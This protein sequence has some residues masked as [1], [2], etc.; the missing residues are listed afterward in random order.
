MRAAAQHL[1]RDRAKDRRS[2]PA[3]VLRDVVGL[4]AQVLSAAAL[5]LRARGAGLHQSD[6]TRALNDDRSIVR[7]WLMRGTLHVVATED[8]RWLVQLL[9]PVFARAG[10]TR[11]TQLGL[12][13]DLKTRGV[14]ALRRI[15]ADAGP[16]TRYELVDRLHGKDIA[17]DPKT[18]AP[19]QMIALAA[20]QGVLC[21][22]P[23]RN[24]GES[25]YVLLDDWVP[26]ALTLTREAALAELARRYFAAY[27]PATVDDLSAWSGIAMAEARSAVVGAKP[28]LADVTIQGQP[29]FVLKD[30]LRQVTAPATPQARLLPAFDA[31]LLG[32]RRR[33][34][35][36][37]PALQRRL[38]RGGGWLHPAV[39]ANGR[40]IG[41]WTLRK[42]GGRGQVQVEPFEGM[43]RAIRAGIEAEVADI[44]RFLDLPV[45]LEIAR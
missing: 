14:A 13:D 42:A 27:G 35:A 33:D 15:L 24:D 39:V 30:R 36:V 18:Q 1:T 10:A 8:I 19:I 7:S 26:P 17:L 2:R 44:G 43:S 34:L 5:G 4:Q 9:G 23:E 38:Q 29:G 25:T 37:P 12:D 22:G 21:V 41:A 11:H 20:M 45:T 28:S 40:A 31:Y 16:L 6:V 3:T 32:Y